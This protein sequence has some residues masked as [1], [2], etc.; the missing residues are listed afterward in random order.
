MMKLGTRVVYSML[1]LVA[2]STVVA[3]AQVTISSVKVTV[4]SGTSTAVY[5]DSSLACGPSGTVVWTLPAGGQFVD[6]GQKLVLAQTG[7][8]AGVGGN[9]DTSDRAQPGNP[10]LA[11]CTTTDH[12]TVMI[13]INNVQ[14]Y[15]NAAGDALNAF[16][17]DIPSNQTQTEASQW[18]VDVANKPN[19]SLQLGYAD[20]EHAACPAGGCFPNP[21]T[22]AS[23]ATYFFGAGVGASGICAS[24]CYDSGALLITG[25]LAAPTAVGRMTGGGSIF[26]PDGTRVTHGFEIHCDITDVPNTLEVNWPAANNFH[27]DTLTAAKCTDDPNINQKPP[28]SSPFDTFVGTGTGKLNGVA[29][30]SITFTFVDAGEPGTSDTAAYLIKDKDG[31]TVLS[32]GATLLTKGNHQ[33]HK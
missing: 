25:K 24:N 12:C 9:F 17:A 2:L 1:G 27:M 14:V 20:N 18:G 5:C 31:N 22:V 28:K 29:G 3:N 16:N 7:L 33:A 13:E 26:L 15:S 6:V 4:T 32:V 21:F 11:E 19:Y 8:I 23:G 30:A 10:T